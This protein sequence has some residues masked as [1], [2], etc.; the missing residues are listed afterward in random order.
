M[1]SNNDA[2]KKNTARTIVDFERKSE[3]LLAPNIVVTP[4]PPTSPESPP[5]LDDCINTT[6]IKRIQAIINKNIKNVI[7][8]N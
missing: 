5:P 4:E 3:V 6:A 8:I 2:N 1:L 7:I